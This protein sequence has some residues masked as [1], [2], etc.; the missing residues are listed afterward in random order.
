MKVKLTSIFPENVKKTI[1]KRIATLALTGVLV[2]SL[3]GCFGPSIAERNAEKYDFT[4]SQTSFSTYHSHFS[5]DD[6]RRVPE[7]MESLSFDY[8]FY[9][10]DLSELPEICP[11]LKR[12]SLDN[13][14]SVDDLSFIYRMPNLEYV[15]LN[16][17]AYVTPELVEYLESNGIEHNITQADLDVAQKVDEIIAEIIT[18]DMSDEEKIQAITLYVIDNYKYRVS[19][20][21]ESN[22]EP[23]ESM[24]ENKG[25]VC[26]SYAYLTNVLLRKAGITSYEIVSDSHA[27]NVLELDGKYYYVDATNIKQ[28]LFPS[29]FLLEKFNIGYFYMQCPTATNGTVMEDYDDTEKV[30]IPQSLIEDIKR[31]EDEKTLWEKYGTTMDARII[32]AIILLVAISIGFNLASKAIENARYSR[33]RRRRRY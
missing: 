4:E 15:S 27:W 12:L 23:L 17:C 33:R 5:D 21:M 9:L 11:N 6:L 7:S 3:S 19:K 20:V 28:P 30:I 32:E 13:C 8:A 10:S 25:G 16:D 29:K 26:A 31:G 24:F 18:D 1:G 22:Q 2:F 14:P